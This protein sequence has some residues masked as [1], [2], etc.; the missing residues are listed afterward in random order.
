MREAEVGL[1][2][3]GT[4]KFYFKKD[5][6]ARAIRE[7]VSLAAL[8]TVTRFDLLTGHLRPARGGHGARALAI[9]VWQCLLSSKSDRGADIAG[10]LKRAQP[11][12][13]SLNR[14]TRLLD[15]TRRAERLDR[16]PSEHINL[17]LI[18]EL[19]VASDVPFAAPVIVH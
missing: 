5:F 10:C 19:E 6:S 4:I 15:R 2:S 9:N 14:L 13:S 1:R 3:T 8:V 16:T 18:E 17:I 12:I 11:D 7:A